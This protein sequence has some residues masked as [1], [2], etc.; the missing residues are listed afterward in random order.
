LEDPNRYF[1]G[2][3]FEIS[4]D[5]LNLSDK[6]IEHLSRLT[7]RSLLTWKIELGNLKR[8]DYLTD[9]NKERI[10]QLEGFIWPLEAILNSGGSGFVLSK[11]KDKGPLIFPGEIEQEKNPLGFY[12]REE[13]SGNE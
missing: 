9:K 3:P 4:I 2:E 8:K 13:G 10:N 5:N 7:F 11:Y 1:D 12:D 6:S